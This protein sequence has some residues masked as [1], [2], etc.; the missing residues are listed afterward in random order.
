MTSPD[1]HGSDRD[2]DLKAVLHER[3]RESSVEQRKLL[4]SLSTASLGAYF[5]ALTVEVKPA[6]LTTQK[7]A[8]CI[9]AVLLFAAMIAGLFAWQADAQRNYVWARA[10]EVKDDEKRKPFIAAKNKWA[11]RLELCMRILRVCFAAGILAGFA[12][13][14]MRVFGV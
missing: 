7:T 13:T 5:L 1:K 4:I 8:I 12:Y 11:R 6:L 2:T 14:L 3:A 10:L 9:G